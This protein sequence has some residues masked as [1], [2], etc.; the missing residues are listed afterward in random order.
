M[1][2]SSPIRSGILTLAFALAAGACGS[3]PSA[4]SGTAG[5]D[6]T[7]PSGNGGTTA[8][9]NGGGTDGTS[10]TGAGGGNA[11]CGA[12]GPATDAPGFGAPAQTGTGTSTDKYF[13]ADVTRDG[14]S[15]R[16]ITNW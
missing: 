3:S 4:S 2:R 10:T 6:G 14:K 9:T 7:S 1:S 12:V 5:T 8:G 16:F 15:Y 13:G 11:S